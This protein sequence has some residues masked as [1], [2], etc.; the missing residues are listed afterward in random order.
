MSLCNMSPPERIEKPSAGQE[1][2]HDYWPCERIWMPAVCCIKCGHTI[3]QNPDGTITE[4][5]LPVH[6]K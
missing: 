6:L 1:C 4:K 2:E 3:I 5:Y